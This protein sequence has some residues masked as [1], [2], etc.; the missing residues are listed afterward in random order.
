MRVV[1]DIRVQ[2]SDQSENQTLRDWF[3]SGKAPADWEHVRD[4]GMDCIFKVDRA[5][6]LSQQT[7]VEVQ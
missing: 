3:A 4:E 6:V 2:C 5:A 1:I 7:I